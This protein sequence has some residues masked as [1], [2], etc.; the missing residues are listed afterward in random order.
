MTHACAIVWAGV[1]VREASLARSGAELECGAGGDHAAPVKA[2]SEVP[3]EPESLPHRLMPDLSFGR[4]RCEY[5]IA[6]V[7]S[8]QAVSQG[9]H[10]ARGPSR[11]PNKINPAVMIMQCCSDAACSGATVAEAVAACRAGVG[12]VRRRRRLLHGR[13]GVHAARGGRRCP[14][15]RLWLPP[16]ASSDSKKP[17]GLKDLERER[18]AKERQ[19]QVSCWAT[20]SNHCPAA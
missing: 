15:P 19:P 5:D 4:E 6:V 13:G 8:A 11:R 9:Q 7:P 10:E 12:G 18:Q 17:R 3:T 2:A 14:R 16:A 1:W 20:P